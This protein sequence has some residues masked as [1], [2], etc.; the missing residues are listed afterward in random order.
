MAISFDGATKQITW[1]DMVN[2][3][4]A[5]LGSASIQTQINSAQAGSLSVDALAQTLAN[6]PPCPGSN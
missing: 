3:L 5:V 2:Y 6:M 1:G 4:A